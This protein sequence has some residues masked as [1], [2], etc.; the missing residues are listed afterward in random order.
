M[1]ADLE[2]NMGEFSGPDLIIRIQHN[3]EYPTA[4]F[5]NEMLMP[6]HQRVESLRASEHQYLEFLVRYQLLQVAINGPQAHIGQSLSDLVINLV[7][8][9]MRGI[10]LDRLPDHLSSLHTSF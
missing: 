3:I 9:R 7:C 5:A 2:A 8:R 6:F 10:I 4:L 1:R